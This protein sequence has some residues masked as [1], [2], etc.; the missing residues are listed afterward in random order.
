MQ[1]IILSVLMFLFTAT[2]A[3]T[4]ENRELFQVDRELFP[5]YP[6]LLRWEKSSAPFT[7]PET[8]AGCHEKQQREWS[9]AVHSL[10]LRD[11]I[12]QGELN[13]GVKA[14][15]HD[16]AR[17]CEGCHS[18]AGMVT[19]ELKKP[20]LAG[21]SPLA[22]AGV[23]CDICHSVSGTSHT[24]TPTREAGNG[25]LVLSPGYDG[26]QGTQL[27]KR[28]PN[29]PDGECGGGFHECR[30]SRLHEQADICAGCH[31]V[32]HHEKQFP[33][34]STYNEWKQSPYA[35][36]N[37]Q[38]QDCHMVESDTFLKSA[39]DFRKPRRSEYRHYFNG[40]N[41]L[42]AFISAQAATR[43]NDREQA[44]RLM[45]Q[46]R[47]AV[48]R[49]QSAAGLALTPIYD[50]GRL[51]ELKIR[52]SNLRA[53][54]N[55]PTSLSNVRQMWLEI[56]ARDQNNRLVMTSGSPGPD[57]SLLPETRI[58]NSD[59]MGSDFHFSHD[60]WVITAFSR[61]ETIPP[62][63]YREV[64]YGIPLLKGVRSLTVEVRLRY[65][66]AD[67]HVAEALL[68][69][70]PEDIDLAGEYGLSS[71]PPLP[72]VEMATVRSRIDMARR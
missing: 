43:G 10:A 17:Q 38:C 5:Y 4:A 40:T 31:Q 25:S 20:G 63:G 7:E 68:A 70:V 54:H 11:P 61:H 58:F 55:L 65:R 56:T 47:M 34:E 26:K 69:A 23:S 46:Y 72:V 19:G 52:V 42:L 60:P 9:G 36:R 67:Q 71:V 22:R 3:A 29:R 62:R 49:L 59:G 24:M 12:Y 32:F 1:R 45:A 28:G 57:G 27:V 30:Q 35:Q 2:I 8:C 39:D 15:G 53:G 41:Y 18:A 14:V 48:K 44:D 21:L 16:V 51:R 66:T 50:S 33:I 13:K 37:I 64:H 6:S